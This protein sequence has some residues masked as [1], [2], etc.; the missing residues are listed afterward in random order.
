MSKKINLLVKIAVFDCG[1]RCVKYRDGSYVSRGTPNIY[2]QVEKF[3][4]AIVY[5]QRS[6]EDFLESY[7]DRE[8]MKK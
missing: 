2:R 5:G 6:A 1:P 4:E 8:N 3:V 7:H